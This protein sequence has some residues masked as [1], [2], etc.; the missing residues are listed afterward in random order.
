MPADYIRNLKESFNN[1]CK[2][3]LLSFAI[4]FMALLGKS[5]NTIKGKIITKDG[6]PASNVNIEVRELKKFTISDEQGVFTFRTTGEEKYHII[7]S[8][9]G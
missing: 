8:F 4:I 9:S 6:S 1:M 3:S 2:K 7:A 5:Q